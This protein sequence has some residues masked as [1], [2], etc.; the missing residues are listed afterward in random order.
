MIWNRS[1][2]LLEDSRVVEGVDWVFCGHTPI[3]RPVI[4]GN[5]VF[6]DTGACLD[7][8]H[9]TVIDI[10]KFTAHGSLSESARGDSTRSCLPSTPR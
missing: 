4:L 5:T 3:D 2:L 7:G 1:R 9:L 10:D 8:G 6:I